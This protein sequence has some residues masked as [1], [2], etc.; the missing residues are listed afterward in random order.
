MIA[1]DGDLTFSPA[2][3]EADAPVRGEVELIADSD[4]LPRVVQQGMLAAKVSLDIATAD[5]KAMLVPDPANPRSRNAPSIVDH[6]VR[7]AKRGV[8]VRVLHAG[9]PSGPALQQLKKAFAKKKPVGGLTIRRCPRL[10][11]KA[12]VVDA[13]WLYLGS[14]NLT[15]AGLGAKG[16]TRRNFEWGVVSESANLV[17]AV[18]GKFNTLWEGGHCEG[19]GRRD[20][21]PVPLEEPEL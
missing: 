14:A 10:H 17:D 12:V 18:M 15:G 2:D 8:E 11:A 6:L 1:R 13:G 19:C 3:L 7:L 9:V 5:F 4:H 20:V 21:C 16:A